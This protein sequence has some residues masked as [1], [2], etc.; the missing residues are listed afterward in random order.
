MFNN[1]ISKFKS[2]HQAA[3]MCKK[4][5]QSRQNKGM[6]PSQ[7]ASPTALP[8]G[9]PRGGAS[10]KKTAAEAELQREQKTLASPFGGWCCEATSG[11]P[12]KA[13]NG[14]FAEGEDGEGFT[15]GEDHADIQE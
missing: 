1:N 12:P 4:P 5:S 3:P 11:G 7:S 9:E 14:G 2:K 6:L 15:Q 8:K 13:A 10:G